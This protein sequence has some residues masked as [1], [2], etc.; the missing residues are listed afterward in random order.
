MVPPE[1]EGRW[2]RKTILSEMLFYRRALS[3][4][5]RAAVDAYL[6]GRYGL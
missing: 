4:G 1:W 2:D 3:V 5:E 6:K